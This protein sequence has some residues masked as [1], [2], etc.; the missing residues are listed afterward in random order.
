MPE[1]FDEAILAAGETIDRAERVKLMQE[2]MVAINE[3]PFA[4]YLYSIDDLYGVQKWVE[5]FEPRP[6]Q[7]IRMIEWAIEP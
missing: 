3:E 6:D 1:G 7:T 2:A 4:I 5:D